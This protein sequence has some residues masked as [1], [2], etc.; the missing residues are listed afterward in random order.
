LCPLTQ[1]TEKI[2]KC[3]T[4]KKKKIKKEKSPKK[5]FFFGPLAKGYPLILPYPRKN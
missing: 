1:L 2:R 4:H 3:K 5:A